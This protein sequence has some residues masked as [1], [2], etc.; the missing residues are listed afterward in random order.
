MGCSYPTELAQN[1]TPQKTVVRDEM[2][3]IFVLKRGA[4]VSGSASLQRRIRLYTA[5]E[6]AWADFSRR[7]RARPSISRP[8][9]KNCGRYLNKYQLIA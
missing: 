5:R 4:E 8:P 7:R 6:R 9:F 2:R 1:V 3:V